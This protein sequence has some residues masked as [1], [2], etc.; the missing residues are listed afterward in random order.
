M[1]AHDEPLLKMH[2]ELEIDEVG[3]PPVAAESVWVK[4]MGENLFQIENVPFFARLVA[5]KDHVEGSFEGNVINFRRH[6]KSSGY[7][8]VR[9]LLNALEKQEELIQQL[10]EV[11][12]EVE[13]APQWNLLAIGIPAGKSFEKA[14]AILREGDQQKWW[15]YEES[16]LPAKPN[17]GLWSWFKKSRRGSQN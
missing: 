17:G 1:G 12:C 15:E 16:C 3:W 10:E 13:G 6:V 5:Y 14:I 8:T 2:F 11:K 9:V 4:R 7:A